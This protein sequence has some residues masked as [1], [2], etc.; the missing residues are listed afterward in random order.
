MIL[1][2]KLKQKQLVMFR[3]LNKIISI[4]NIIYTQYKIERIIKT[5]K[6]TRYHARKNS[7]ISD[8]VETNQREK[9]NFPSNI[10][11]RRSCSTNGIIAPGN[12]SSVDRNINAL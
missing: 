2:R 9:T 11:I 8:D 3:K 6:N 1:K 12:H 5:L 10:I 7:S 4:K